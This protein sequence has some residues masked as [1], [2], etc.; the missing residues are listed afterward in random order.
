MPKP[1]CKATTARGA[2]CRRAAAPDSDLCTV[3]L[4]VPVGRK[5][6]LTA[7]MQ[8]R[9]VDLLRAG[10]MP[11]LAAQVAG[12]PRST[13]YLWLKTGREGKD[14]KLTRFAVEVDKARGEGEARHVAQIAQQ[15]KKDWRAGAWLLSRSNPD[16]YGQPPAA[17]SSDDQGASSDRAT[18]Q[19][20]L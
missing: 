20:G 15:A 16:R 11:D 17:R 10:V 14:S 4:G 13:F 3:H 1:R 2:R 8:T 6:T 5:I 7:E 9:V 12:I 18:D 19:A